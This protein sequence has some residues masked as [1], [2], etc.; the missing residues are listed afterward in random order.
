M[1]KW[2]PAHYIRRA[3]Y[4]TFLF[5][6]FSFLMDAMTLETRTKCLCSSGNENMQHIYNSEVCKSV[7]LLACFFT[8]LKQSPISTWAKKCPNHPG[9]LLHLPPKRESP[10]ERTTFQKWAYCRR[11]WRFICENGS[12]FFLLHKSCYKI[13]QTCFPD[14]CHRHYHVYQ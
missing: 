5:H 3:L 1:E 11:K 9:K 12:Y 2:S 8:L 6:F 10:F 4:G 14:R 7:T 13:G